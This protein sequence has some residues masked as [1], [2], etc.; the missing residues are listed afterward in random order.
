MIVISHEQ[1][2]ISN[3]CIWLFVQQLV[4]DNSNANIK[5]LHY[6]P[7][8]RGIH[9]LLVDSP[10]KE[11]VMQKKHFHIDG[12][13]QE[14]RNSIVNA[15]ELRLPCT[16][17]SISRHHPPF[18]PELQF[19]KYIL[20]CPAVQSSPTHPTL[21]DLWEAVFV[22]TFSRSDRK[23]HQMACVTSFFIKYCGHHY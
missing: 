21:Q 18:L 11:P 14:R 1:H 19:Q 13:V 16:N 10:H 8:V 4:Q 2:N 5:A 22:A 7:F 12:L 20:L 15:L 9:H 3:Q 23:Q 6:W 17:P